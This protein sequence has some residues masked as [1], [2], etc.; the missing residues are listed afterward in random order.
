MLWNGQARCEAAFLFIASV[1]E[2]CIDCCSSYAQLIDH[3]FRHADLNP[4]PS[5]CEISTGRTIA[6]SIGLVERDWA[7]RDVNCRITGTEVIHKR[8]QGSGR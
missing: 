2:I 1:I 5:M 7:I 6:I 3:V 8:V 4:A